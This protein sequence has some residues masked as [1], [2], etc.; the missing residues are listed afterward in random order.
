[1]AQTHEALVTLEE[2]QI[3]GG[4]GSAVLLALQAAGLHLPVLNLGIKD[5]FTDHGDPAKLLSH[6]GLDA[7]GIQASIEARFGALLPKP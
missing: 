7:Q 6:E 4:A 3:L 5:V 2:G 1:V